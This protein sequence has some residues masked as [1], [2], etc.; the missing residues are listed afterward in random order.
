MEDQQIFQPVPPKDITPIITGY[1]TLTNTSCDCQTVRILK[2][3]LSGRQGKFTSLFTYLY[4][5]IITN[6]QN[7]NLSNTLKAIYNQELIHAN[8]LGN[9][10]NSFCGCPRFSSEGTF[11]SARRVNYTTNQ[12]QFLQQNIRFIE[13]SI[14]LYQNAIARVTNQSLKQLLSE[15]LEEDR[16]HLETFRSFL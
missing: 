4:Q 1:T 7:Q 16:R 2:R 13:N 12:T 11:W 10:I 3:L 6:Q 9:A 14:I 15:I 5:S 8:L